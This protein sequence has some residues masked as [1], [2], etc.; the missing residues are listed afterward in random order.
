MEMTKKISMK[1]SNPFFNPSSP[2][3]FS[4]YKSVYSRKFHN[5]V[6]HSMSVFL[7]LLGLKPAGFTEVR[8][9]F[10]YFE[11]GY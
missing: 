6:A 11:T 2:L 7:V 9:P 5:V 10:S 1:F 8:V 3:Y 4:S